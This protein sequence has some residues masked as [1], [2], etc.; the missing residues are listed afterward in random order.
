MQ[1]NVMDGV[2]LDDT[3]SPGVNKGQ[4]ILC[5]VEYS[6]V[7]FAVINVSDCFWNKNGF[8]RCS[9]NFY[10][11]SLLWG[12]LIARSVAAP[13]PIVDSKRADNT[14]RIEDRR[15]VGRAFRIDPPGRSAA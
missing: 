4:A 6:G 8:A 3:A 12:K 13:I 11:D 5:G 2:A 9:L 14:L 10:G 1:A 15:K 7:I